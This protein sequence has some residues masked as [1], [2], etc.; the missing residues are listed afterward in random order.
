MCSLVTRYQTKLIHDF[1]E[2]AKIAANELAEEAKKFALSDEIGLQPHR[3]PGGLAAKPVE[4][5]RFKHWLVRKRLRAFLL[6][7]PRKAK[8][9]APCSVKKTSE[10]SAEKETHHVCEKAVETQKGDSD[11]AAAEKSDDHVA[12]LLM[13]L[14]SGP[15]PTTEAVAQDKLSK[16]RF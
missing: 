1:V 5:P 15:V 16:T 3:R 4:P 6:R 13:G 2:Q 9:R 10:R 8:K 14:K 12:S 7:M 11:A